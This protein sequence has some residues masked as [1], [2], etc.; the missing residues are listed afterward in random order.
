MTKMQQEQDLGLGGW[1]A[2]GCLKDLVGMGN[3][4][5]EY[6]I[7]GTVEFPPI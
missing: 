3:D 5:V 1:A 6:E 2:V 4:F 7:P